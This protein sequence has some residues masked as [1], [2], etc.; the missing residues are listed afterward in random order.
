M[1]DLHHFANARNQQQLKERLN[2]LE[3]K[4]RQQDSKQ[5]KREEWQKLLYN[6]SVR[7]DANVE[8]LTTEHDIGKLEQ[9]SAELAFDYETNHTELLRI[10]NPDNYPSLEYKELA[11]KCADRLQNLRNLEWYEWGKKQTKQQVEQHFQNLAAIKEKKKA[12]LEAPHDFWKDPWVLFSVA[13]VV[14]GAIICIFCWLHAINGDP[15]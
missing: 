8:A 1:D 9:I 5:A 7:L 12:A 13:L 14:V 6:E 4:L 3:Q 11:T 15:L 2:S 10:F